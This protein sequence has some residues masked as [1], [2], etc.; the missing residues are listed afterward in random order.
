VDALMKK[1]VCIVGGG[2]AGWITLSYLAATTD[3]DLTI[4]HSDEID[5]IGV[6]E[7]TT[8][9]VRHVAKMVGL[10]ETVWMKDGLST[11][12]YGIDF[13]NWNTP[14]SRWFHSFDDLLPA[15]AFSQPLSNNGYTKYK[16]EL[17]SI[18]YFLTLRQLNPNL[19]NTDTFNRL[20]GSHQF[21][22]E[23]QLSPYSTDNTTNI[24]DFPGYAYHINAYEFGQSLRK[25][26]SA[27]K[28]KEIVSTVTDI[29]YNEHGISKL[30]LK[31]GAEIVA[32]VFIDC[33]GF[34]RL[35]T[36]KLT[37]FKEYTD[38][39]NDR[40]I[41]GPV[42]NLQLYKPATE[43]VAQDAGWVWVTPTV[44]QVGTGYV[45]SSAFTSDDTAVKVMKDY[46]TSRGHK[47]EPV[48]Q[49]KFTGGRL[50]DIAVKNVISN[51]LGQS[52]LE[53]LEAT[54][55]MIT[56]ITAIEFA[57]QYNKHKTWNE[58]S[59]LVLN[60]V[61]TN[62]LEHT[63]DFVRYH[64]ELTDRT[65]TEYWRSV[66]RSTAVQEVSDI[67]DIRVKKES[68]LNGFN[69]ASMLV[70]YD[71]QYTNKLPELT[72][73]QLDNYIHYTNMLKQH[74]EYLVKNNLTIKQ[75]LEQING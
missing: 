39:V 60:K 30:I 22:L 51:G 69:W 50:K 68:L 67:I 24:G 49:L 37:T 5:I 46:W 15:Q 45:Y 55:V 3:L 72:S 54:S 27:D 43:A 2:T 44:G 4:I 20:H 64:Y 48:K 6:G 57:N 1:S 12:K 21:L 17:T 33:T 73:T 16:R 11:Y 35:L 70:G 58:K 74:Y 31:D 65:D 25:H 52:F 41:F 40:V 29:N 7:S 36:E 62:L 63:K 47:W 23:N 28:F 75:R 32:D 9:A 34:R 53:P 18:E 61:I 13:Q 14:G 56:C 8:P 26:T 42:K 19:Y 66:R 10:D 38:L 59:S 71:K